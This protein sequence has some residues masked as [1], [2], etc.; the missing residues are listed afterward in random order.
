MKLT[1][2]DMMRTGLLGLGAAVVPFGL[3][4]AASKYDYAEL[5]RPKVR[6]HFFRINETIEGDVHLKDDQ[7]LLHCTVKGKVFVEGSDTTVNACV[8]E[9]GVE[10]LPSAA[11]GVFVDGNRVYDMVTFQQGSFA[12]GVHMN[13][14]TNNLCAGKHNRPLVHYKVKEFVADARRTNG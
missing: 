3:T 10:F 1:R 14:F 4:K 2:R 9:G 11:N 7:G 5:G 8:I 6:S 13:Y 12:G